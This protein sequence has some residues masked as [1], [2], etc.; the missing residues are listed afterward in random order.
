M[1]KTTRQAVTL[2][3]FVALSLTS[4]AQQDKAPA[5]PETQ[6]RSRTAPFVG[7]YDV[8]M[9]R[10]WP[11]GFGGDTKFVTPPSRIELLSEQ[12]TKGFEQEGLL[13]RA[14][15]PRKGAA[16]G[17]GSPS[18]WQLNS[19]DQVDLIWNDGFTG[20][21]LTLRK[22]GDKLRGWAHPHFDAGHFI[23]HIAHV[24]AKRIACDSTQ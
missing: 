18:Y 20:V 7:C 19:N 12:G 5:S 1:V 2:I 15:P 4:V 9:G 10:W 16:P 23:P 14:M 8:N 21:T 17:R 24:T 11:W 13:I 3:F 22:N 6:P